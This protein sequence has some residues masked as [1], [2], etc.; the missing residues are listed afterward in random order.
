[1]NEFVDEI[2]SIIAFERCGYTSEFIR[3][4]IIH[5][6]LTAIE[7]AERE[8]ILALKY[9]EFAEVY[10][11][12]IVDR[13]KDF[14]VKLHNACTQHQLSAEQEKLL[15]DLIVQ[16][17]I[18][19]QALCHLYNHGINGDRIPYITIRDI[20]PE[21]CVQ[22]LSSSEKVFIKSLFS[23][24]AH[25][26]SRLKQRFPDIST[27]EA[28]QLTLRVFAFNELRRVPVPRRD[29]REVLQ[30]IIDYVERFYESYCIEITKRVT[31]KELKEKPS[32]KAPKILKDV[33]VE[34]FNELGRNMPRLYE[35]QYKG[36]EATWQGLVDVLGGGERYVVLK[37]PTGSGKSEVF[38]FT[39]ILLALVRKYICKELRLQS[40]G[41]SPVTMIIYPRL[42][43]AWDQFDRLVRYTQVLNKILRRRG[44]EPITIS[45]NNMDVLSWSAYVEAIERVKTR[46][47][48]GGEVEDYLE[49]PYVR[50]PVIIGK[51]DDGKYY[52]RFTEKFTFFKCPNGTYPEIHAIE[53]DGEIRYHSFVCLSKDGKEEDFNYIKVV[54]D[55]VFLAPGDIHVT[56]FETLRLNLFSKQWERLLGRD[57]IAGGPLLIVIDE[58]HTYTGITGARYAYL[59]RRVMTKIKKLTKRRHGFVVMGLSATI[60]KD[61]GRKFLR[62]LFLQDSDKNVIEVEP[63]E[64]ETIPAGADYFYIVLPNFKEAIDAVSV[65]V[66]TL[67]VL[68]FNM[69][70]IPGV[71]KK[72]LA[73]AD[74][75][76]VVERLRYVLKDAFVRKISVESETF[77]GGLQDLRNPLHNAF[78]ITCKDFGE[79]EICESISSEADHLIK[80]LPRIYTVKSWIDGEL[81][82]RYALEYKK[83]NQYTSIIRKYTS[84]VR[85]DLES[86]GLI[87]ATSTLELGV[88]YSDVIVIYQ[89]GAP[90]TISALIQR[91]GRGGR[92]VAQNP[93]LR[94]AI[95]IQ[96]SPE[97]PHQSYLLEIFLRTKSL[98]EALNYDILMVSTKNP[99][100]LKQTLVGVILDYYVLVN[101][102]VPQSLMK[103]IISRFRGSRRGS[104]EYDEL[105]K[106]LGREFEC[107][108]LSNFIKLQ[109]NNEVFLEYLKDIL[110]IDEGTIRS[111]LN[112]II[113]DIELNQKCKGV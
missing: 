11:N 61:S 47:A 78:R 107:N 66:Q 85:E 27:F 64:S 30:M 84:K 92:R 101:D 56:L 54:K 113:D 112:E 105:I 41:T 1:M 89:H 79:K 60:P 77:K 71:G 23:E 10:I 31:L 57:D 104:K 7:D 43:L 96:L 28:K 18:A 103:Y 49:S 86:P 24:M 95:A 88:D 50:I 76:D 94:T 19:V 8:L 73:F 35:F 51:R 59:L 15:R 83:Y 63:D 45:I 58:I 33:I 40:C 75:L 106:E 91:A 90:I 14:L 13:I 109:Q 97:T 4:Y 87:V 20:D 98:R 12:D 99:V 111:I 52:T 5:A 38:L 21:N 70:L 9:D 82:W 22:A 48:E 69:P 74:N 44:E 67:M 36:L 110:R 108:E 46:I 3:R 42:A 72:T 53:V 81:W 26:L 34:F 32:C 16:H 80:L 29:V 100:L 65:S 2:R 39:S 37:A 62:D 102:Q 17:N 68:H 6:A 55:R 25:Y 93:L